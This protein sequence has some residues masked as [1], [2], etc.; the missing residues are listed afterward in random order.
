[1]A[2]DEQQ[3]DRG[4]NHLAEHWAEQLAVAAKTLARWCYER[5]VD[6][7]VLRCD[8]TVLWRAVDQAIGRPTTPAH[9]ERPLWE[10][11]AA[12][13]R[14][15]R[16]WDREHHVTPPPTSPCPPCAVAPELCPVHAHPRCRACSGRL[17]AT[18]LAEGFDTHPCC[19]SGTATAPTDSV[20]DLL[21]VLGAMPLAGAG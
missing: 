10:R 5:G 8:T 19:D 18:A 2:I 7:R 13:L 3:N 6:E 12:L 9:L 21:Q 14:Q 17:H 16:D 4:A 15:R 11:T 20:H 1:M